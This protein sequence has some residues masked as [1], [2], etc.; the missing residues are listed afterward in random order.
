MT[1]TPVTSDVGSILANLTT[2]PAK[3]EKAG[4]NFSDVLQKQTQSEQPTT[5]RQAAAK[6]VKVENRRTDQVKDS[7]SVEEQTAT[8]PTMEEESEVTV[9]AEELATQMF[10]SLA[11]ELGISI[12][13]LE[14][15]MEELG[16]T[17]M[18]LLQS[19]NLM[20]VF[21]VVGGA[22]DAL[23]LLTNE[24]LYASFTKLNAELT[25]GLEE[26]AKMTGKDVSQIQELLSQISQQYTEGTQQETA[27]A[28]QDTA[29]QAEQEGTQTVEIVDARTNPTEGMAK[30]QQ[31]DGSQNQT[32]EKQQ[33]DSNDQGTLTKENPFMVTN[34]L[35]QQV[36]VVT[37]SASYTE[38]VYSTET[39]MIMDQIMEFM[40]IQVGDDISR[41]EMQLQ[42][43]SLGTVQVQIAAKDGVITAQFTA[44]NE[45]VKNALESQMI[46][47]RETF[48]AQGI[49][50]ES[51]EVAVQS[52]AFDRNLNQGK[53]QQNFSQQEGK[54]STKIR[55]LN[56]NLLEEGSEDL[57]DEA[58]QL[59]AQMMEQNGTTVDYTV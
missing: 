59:A 40:K 56:L 33:S 28:M 54:S 23:S 4:E 43:E 26:I 5:D 38:A 47:L 8:A 9:A 42:P 57:L 25:V 37:S 24:E 51:I 31:T 44:Q 3:N 49:K 14:N 10:Q 20:Q 6:P 15:V 36:E 52:Q 2:Q 22:N 53:G 55:R 18:D 58:D 12:E 45:M 30:L 19:D 34:P 29:I 21:V 16:M 1:S 27:D 35:Q 13:E 48:D 17:M 41:L 32:G 50:V 11:S 39:Q 46:Q 7:K